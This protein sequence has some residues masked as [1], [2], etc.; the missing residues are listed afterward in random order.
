M[1]RELS[2]AQ[3]LLSVLDLSHSSS[4]S[5]FENLVYV[6][7]C[8]RRTRE[9]LITFFLGIS[10]RLC[11]LDLLCPT[12]TFV[13]YQHNN[14]LFHVNA[15][16]LHRSFPFVQTVKAF[17][18]FQVENQKDNLRSLKEGVP[19][20][21][22]VFTATE[23]KKID[24]NFSTRDVDLFDSIVDPNGG[25]VFLNKPALAVSFDDTGLTNLGVSD[26]N[27]LRSLESTLRRI[28]LPSIL[29]NSFYISLTLRNHARLMFCPH[30]ISSEGWEPNSMK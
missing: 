12:I 20:L 5:F 29:L 27:K 15:H 18:I 24:S 16:T 10:Y 17:S 26:R 6:F 23:I 30:S 13:S 21:L 19:D 28:W 9:I 22:V 7:P 2:A 3:S 4:K 25:D 1:K 11:L 8:T 14:G